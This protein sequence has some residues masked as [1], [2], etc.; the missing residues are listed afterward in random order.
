MQIHLKRR[1]RVIGLEKD[2]QSFKGKIQIKLWRSLR[3][4]RIC[5]KKLQPMR[6]PS[7]MCLHSRHV[8]PENVHTQDEI[9]ENW[10]NY[11][12]TLKSYTI[13]SCCLIPKFCT[14]HCQQESQF[15][16]TL[17]F[18]HYPYMVSDSDP[19]VTFSYEMT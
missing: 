6:E 12:N 14:P 15:I 1:S 7:L 11:I 13:Q 16:C 9:E 8:V 17:Y 3:C 2:I 4:Q 5:C 19:S 18:V 10:H